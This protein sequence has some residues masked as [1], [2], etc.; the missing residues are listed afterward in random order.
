L[1][2]LKTQLEQAGQA[3]WVGQV[4]VQ[5]V[6]AQAWLAHAQGKGSEA[7]SLMRAAVDLEDGSEKHVAME[8]RLY[9]MREL[10]GDLLLA[11]GQ[12]QAALSAY[13]AAMASTPE[14]LRGFY[15]AAKA[16]QA[17]GDTGK[18]VLYFDRLA[19]LTRTGDAARAEVREARAFVAVK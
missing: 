19:R 3:Y 15:G 4:E 7:V 11:Q 10:L 17:S 16:A 5:R 18:A 1:Q 9:P 13:E 14:R 8:N 2:A 12:A 6:A